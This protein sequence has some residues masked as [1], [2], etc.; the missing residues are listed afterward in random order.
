VLLSLSSNSTLVLYFQARLEHTYVEP[1]LKLY[2]KGKQILDYEEV[3]NTQTY[4]LL[5]FLANTHFYP[6][7]TFASKVGAHPSG[8]IYRT[9]LKMVV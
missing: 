3:I 1:L 8:G 5:A 9:L 6:S 2:T 7:L 4:V